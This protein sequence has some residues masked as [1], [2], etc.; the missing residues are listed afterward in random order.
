MDKFK[1]VVDGKVAVAVSRGYGAGW[2]TWGYIDPLDGRLN[3]L[4]AEDKHKEA[5]A[6]A[7]NLYPDAYLVG[8]RDVEIVWLPIGTRFRINE[9]DGFEEIETLDDLVLTA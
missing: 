6:L 7:E 2:S 3:A 8:G 1:L 5:V 9:Y 4:F